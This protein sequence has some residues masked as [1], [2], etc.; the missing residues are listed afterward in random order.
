MLILGVDPGALRGAYAVL[1]ASGPSSRWPI[2]RRLQTTRRGGSMRPYCFR[3]CSKSSPSQTSTSHSFF[4]RNHPS[5]WGSGAISHQ[6]Q[7][8]L[9]LQRLERNVQHHLIGKDSADE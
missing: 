9:E 6:E 8:R 1:D 2:C 4:H 3:G 7:N 5:L